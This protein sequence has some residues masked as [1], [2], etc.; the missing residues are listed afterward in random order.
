[1]LGYG[2]DSFGER[3]ADIYDRWYGTQ[4][5]E[6]TTLQTVDTLA[7]LAGGD[8]A[9]E[10]GIGTGRIAIPLAQRGFT[11]QGID[12]SEAM[13]EKLRQK[14]GSE[15][16]Q[17]SIGNF[18]EVAVEGRFDLIFVVFNTLFNLTSQ[19]EQLRCFRNV[20][21]RLTNGGRFV[22][23]SFVPD[24]A[25]LDTQNVRAV[26][27]AADSV[28]LELAGHDRVSQVVDYQYLVIGSGNTR[29][30]PVP[31]R[32][33]W[34]SELDLMAQLAGLTRQHRWA[35]WDRSPFTADSTQHVSVYAHAGTQA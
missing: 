26:N 7:D 23:E 20:A 21:G 15:S 28:V 14:P 25:G 22:V 2:P 18:A 34:P 27:I 11:V 31:Q 10:L 4:I 16:L 13:V 3:M 8:N 19:E 32:Y 35:G 30:F 1:M 12:A 6:Q 17:V 24:V 5:A 29:L 33:A 9:L